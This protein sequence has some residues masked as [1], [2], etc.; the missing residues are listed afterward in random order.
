MKGSPQFD[1]LILVFTVVAD[2]AVI[3]EQAELTALLAAEFDRINARI[4]QAG[5]DPQALGAALMELLGPLA[6]EE[7]ASAK[8]KRL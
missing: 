4:A 7:P 5:G 3:P 2:P 8:R 6:S 1:T